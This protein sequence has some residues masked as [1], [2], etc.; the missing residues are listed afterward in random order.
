MC[1]NSNAY[2][3]RQILPC[4]PYIVC[5]GPMVKKKLWYLTQRTLITICKQHML[6]RGTRDSALEMQTSTNW[7][8]MFVQWGNVCIH[9]TTS[10]C[11]WCDHN[12]GCYETSKKL[13]AESSE[14]SKEAHDLLAA[15]G[16]QLPVTQDVISDLEQ[17]VMR[18]VYGDTKSK[19]LPDTRAAKW[20]AQKKK[21]TIRL[22]PDWDNL[23]QHL[24]RANY[25]AYLLKH[26]KLQNHPSPISH[27]WHLVNVLC[28]LSVQHSLHFPSPCRYLR[29]RW[30]LVVKAV[31]VRTLI[32]TDV[33]YSVDHAVIANHVTRVK[34]RY[35]RM[36]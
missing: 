9:N 6:L 35:I 34:K 28:L 17:F 10:H 19:S 32:L 21:N 25:L 29:K 12:S 2:M 5:S 13:I 1:Q 36:V 7:R 14:K 18:Y 22:V 26:Y 15:C 16:M 33:V 11:N 24:A 20:R 8:P 23:H 3:Q 27:G 30:T 31:K 4:S